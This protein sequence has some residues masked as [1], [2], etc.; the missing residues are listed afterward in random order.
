M[1][2]CALRKGI[3]FMRQSTI[4]SFIMIMLA[5]IS[6]FLATAG[7]PP[8]QHNRIV[9]GTV[10][11]D[12]AW[13]WMLGL[14]KNQYSGPLCGA[15]L[16]HPKWAIT[17]AHCTEADKKSVVSADYYHVV[18]GIFD[19]DQNYQSHMHAIKRII[20]HP[21]YDSDTID[22]DIALLELT[23][24]ISEIPIL[25]IFSGDISNFS[26]IAL[27]WGRISSQGSFSDQLREVS[28]PIVSF[29]RCV[30]STSYT[31]TKNMFCAGYPNGGK[32]ACEGD[33]GGP[34]VIYNDHHWQLAGIVSWGEGCAE[35]G[36]YGFFT[37]VPN[38]YSFISSYVPLQ[39]S[40]AQADINHDSKID[41]QDVMII[42]NYFSTDDPK[43]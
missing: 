26:G 3:V 35:P 1:K 33:S 15:A 5:F 25:D 8:R 39:D 29:Q 32:D 40:F 31:V 30:E 34:F 10:S 20:S 23:S 21:E 9:G 13:P 28:L 18:S 12:N 6:P 41:L 22:N 7:R 2:Q 16:I 11:M 43:E 24:E 14:V 36:Y 17:A 38:Y 27:G 42:F 37:K 19:F 4:F